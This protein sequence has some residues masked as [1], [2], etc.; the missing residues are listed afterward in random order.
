VK[1][2]VMMVT[3]AACVSACE[4]RVPSELRPTFDEMINL[5]FNLCTEEG[6]GP[7][8][9]QVRNIG[10]AELAIASV[11]F[12]AS[13]DDADALTSFD[14]PEV[15]STT[16]LADD[17]AFIQFTYRVPGGLTQRAVLVIESNAEV[18]PTLSVPVSTQELVVDNRDEI[19]GDT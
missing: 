6:T 4:P 19:C 12:T 10:D 5:P 18:K 9:L 14:A 2:T 3:M 7:A 1:K 16:L 11:A 8:T 15:D 17:E 13:P